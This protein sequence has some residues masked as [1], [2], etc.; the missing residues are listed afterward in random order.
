MDP[1]YRLRTVQAACELVDFFSNSP[2]NELGVSELAEGLHFSKTA[3]YRLLQNLI[4]F[5]YIQENANT[6]KYR[7][8]VKFLLMG[9]VVCERIDLARESESVLELLRDQTG[10]T[11][12]LNVVTPKG[13]VCIA[14]RQTSHQLRF[15]TRV[16]MILPW[17][18][19]SAGKVL[20]AFSPEPFQE[21]ILAGG[22]LVAYTQNTVTDS[23]ALRT[24]LASIKVNGYATSDAEVYVGA[25]AAAA[26][27]RDGDG[28][29]SACVSVV[30]P[31]DRME[32][33]EGEIVRLVT[34]AAQTISSRLGFALVLPAMVGLA[35]SCLT[36]A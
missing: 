27:I 22:E 10:E 26:P 30:G 21:Q 23:R 13:P 11:V 36:V 16:G 6:R 20:L 17:H 33:R 32:S 12:H 35:S 8:G 3:V 25:W 15:F 7:F 14:E 28:S 34:A 24:E 19:G 4:E 29:V 9:K 1:R 18:A 5:G 31:H 2:M